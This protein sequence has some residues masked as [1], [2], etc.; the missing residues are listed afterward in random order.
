[1]QRRSTI[2]FLIA[3]L[4][5]GCGD[6]GS[7]SPPPPTMLSGR[8]TPRTSITSITEMAET[9]ETVAEPAEEHRFDEA[10]EALAAGRPVPMFLSQLDAE[11]SND[12]TGAGPFSLQGSIRD[13]LARWRMAPTDASVQTAS[14]E[15]IEK[16]IDMSRLLAMHSEIKAAITAVDSSD[17]TAARARWDRAA[18]W[19]STLEDYYAHRA[20]TAAANIWGASSTAITDENL[21]T[22]TTDLFARGAL[23]IDARAADNLRDTARQLLVYSTKYPYLSAL[24][25]AT[26]FESRAQSMGDLEYPRSEG[27]AFFNAFVTAFHGRATQGSPIETMTRTARA[28][29][30]YGVTAATGPS[31]LAVIHDAGALY[32]SLTAA[33]V[34]AYATASDSDR[35]ATRSTLRGVVDTL[36]EALTY[37]RQDPDALRAKITSAEGRSTAGDHAGAAAL[38]RDVQQGLDAI[39]SAGM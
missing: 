10:A 16:T 4:A 3:A 8:Y 9:L 28:R 26:V 7:S 15:T 20:D 39:S 19:F 17:W 22:R 34:A 11:F 23:L 29:W 33:G 32:A 24:N 30:A 35:A 14:G 13:A 18:A 21:A 12:A 36:D 2:V 37:A 6:G 25:Y 5:G 27:G 38:L 1:M 31:R